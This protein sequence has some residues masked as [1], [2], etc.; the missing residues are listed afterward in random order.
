MNIRKFVTQSHTASLMASF[1]V[2]EPEVVVFPRLLEPARSY[3]S[4]ASSHGIG[5]SYLIT[6]KRKQG[7]RHLGAGWQT[8]DSVIS[9]TKVCSL[10]RYI[11]SQSVTLFISLA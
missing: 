11:K 1:N 8:V 9:V 5:L 10:K 3:R 6:S 2:H 4:G 7:Q